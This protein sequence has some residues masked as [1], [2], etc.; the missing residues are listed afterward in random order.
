MFW[1]GDLIDVQKF[2]TRGVDLYIRLPS[3]EL[4][5]GTSNKV[6]VF[7]TATAGIVIITISALFLWCRMAKQRGNKMC[8]HL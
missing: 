6:I 7:T 4:D 5:K 8:R 3:S 1:G 2:S